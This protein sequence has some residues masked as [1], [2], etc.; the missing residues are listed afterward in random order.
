MT[1]AQVAAQRASDI[2][3]E[4]ER[5]MDLALARAS[6]LVTELPELQKQ[7][8]LNSSWAQPAV[9]SVCAALGDMSAARASIIGA[10]KSL[11][12]IQRKLGVTLMESPNN[13]KEGDGP[14]VPATARSADIVVPLRA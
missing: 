5:A 1:N 8:G 9:A 2:I 14:V 11:S 3:N 10:H 4:A 7:A 13:S 12:A 6:T